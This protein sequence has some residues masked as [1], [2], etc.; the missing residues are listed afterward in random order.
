MP[1]ISKPANNAD[2]ALNAYVAFLITLLGWA[3]V[4]AVVYYAVKGAT[5][6]TFPEST[7]DFWAG[8]IWIAAAFAGRDAWRAA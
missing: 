3:A 6:W 2:R 4:V 8:C 7:L 1:V 5:G